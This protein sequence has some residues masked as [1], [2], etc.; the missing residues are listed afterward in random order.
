M[1]RIVEIRQTINDTNLL[2]NIYGINELTHRLIRTI[3]KI[4]DLNMEDLEYLNY[5]VERSK[6]LLQRVYEFI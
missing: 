4:P 6:L 5:A 3:E 2:Q 1:V